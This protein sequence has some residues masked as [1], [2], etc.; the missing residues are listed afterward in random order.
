MMDVALEDPLTYF[1]AY[2]SIEEH[3]LRHFTFHEAK[4]HI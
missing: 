2:S 1:D 4:L 3:L